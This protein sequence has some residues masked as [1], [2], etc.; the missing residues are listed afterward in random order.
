VKAEVVK[1]RFFV[2]LEN[3]ETAAV[4][5]ISEKTVQRH[6]TFAK[7]WLFRAMRQS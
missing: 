7:A 2:G 6:W 4:L 5:G 3:S 1:L